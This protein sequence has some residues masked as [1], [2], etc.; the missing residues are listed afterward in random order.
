MDH[1]QISQFEFI[2][3]EGD[4]EGFYPLKALIHIFQ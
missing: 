4:S 1:A 2:T 3:E